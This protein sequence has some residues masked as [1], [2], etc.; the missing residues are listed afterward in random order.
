MKEIVLQVPL[1]P[2]R[3]WSPDQPNLY[4]ASIT[5][6]VDGKPVDGWI[7]R[8]GVRKWEVRGGDFYLNNHRFFVRGFGDDYIYP[9][10]LSSPALREFHR[11]HLEIAK[12]YG[13]VYVRHHSHCEVPEFFDAADEVG[14]MIQPELPYYGNI[15][16]AIDPTFFRPKQDLLELYTHYRRYVSF[17]TYCTGNEGYMGSPLDREL[18]RLGKQLDPTRLMQHQD[19]GNNVPGNSDFDTAIDIPWTPGQALSFWGRTQV[20]KPAKLDNTRP[21]FAHEY[22]NLATDEDPR[23][24]SKYTGAIR[25]P[26]SAAAF[27]QELQRNGLSWDWGIACLDAG[28]QLKKYYQKRGLESARLDPACD[29]YIYWTIVDVGSPSAQGLLDQFWQPKKTLPAE[30]RQFNGPVAIL[31]NMTPDVP[32]LAAGETR[33]VE[34]WISNFDT[35]PINGKTL[36]WILAG[37]E[38]PMAG[39][40]DGVQVGVGEVKKIG[41]TILTAPTIEKPRHAKL[42]VSLK[43]ASCRTPGICGCSRLAS[44]GPTWGTTSPRRK[45]C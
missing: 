2:F 39:T 38:T 7:E 29:G 15:P 17:S 22:L 44:R 12:R 43:A 42:T 24:E 1:D 6:T 31:A 16:S 26:V 23:L 37:D 18:Y 25:P 13:F 21:F 5:L 8:F 41:E 35:K 14:L 32:V 28:S 40:I 9:L 34:W 33:K 45:A 30:F 20:G 36:K 27:K 11:K 4:K 19:G 10:T 3:P